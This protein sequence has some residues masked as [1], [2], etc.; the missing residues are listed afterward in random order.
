MSLSSTESSPNKSENPMDQ[1][2]LSAKTTSSTETLVNKSLFYSLVSFVRSSL[3]SFRSKQRARDIESQ[4]ED[5]DEEI[6]GPTFH[7]GGPENTKVR[8]R[9]I[10]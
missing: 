4:T 2:P 10:K 9:K 1:I 3:G 8:N 7:I 6:V 5:G